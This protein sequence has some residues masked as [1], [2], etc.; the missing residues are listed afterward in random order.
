MRSKPT[1]VRQDVRRILIFVS[2]ILK[3]TKKGQEWM[4][5]ARREW[6]GRNAIEMIQSGKMNQ[7]MVYIHARYF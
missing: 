5:Q 3:D 2:D 6:K 1:T 4:R 7:V